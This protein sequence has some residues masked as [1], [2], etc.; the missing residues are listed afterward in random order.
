MADSWTGIEE[1]RAIGGRSRFHRRAIDEHGAG[2]VQ[3]G[4]VH[5]ASP[6]ELLGRLLEIPG[7]EA[8]SETTK[9]A[10]PQGTAGG[11]GVI[12]PKDLRFVQEVPLSA[13]H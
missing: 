4:N 6:Q 2:K 12:R 9:L 11:R 3:G 1:N 5:P 7:I 13:S 10:A 8:T